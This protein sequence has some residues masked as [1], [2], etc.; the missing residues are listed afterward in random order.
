MTSI[1]VF[2]G[3]RSG[4]DP[5][6]R[7]A[8]IAFG[9]DIAARDL[10]LVYGGGNVGLMG[11]VAQSVLDHSGSVTGIIPD[12][13]AH[14]EV[15]HP[16]LTTTILVPDLFQRKAQMIEMS[17][18]FVALPGGIGTF[19]ELLE[20]VAW[21]QLKQLRCPIG[22]LDVADY[23]DPWFRA[24]EHSIAQGF[25]DPAEVN[26]IVRTAN[27][28]ELLNAMQAGFAAQQ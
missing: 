1:C 24:L 26:G 7:E 3:A 5:R 28:T 6:Y 23:F 13:L 12:F 22:V 2:C 14:Q 4:G 18:A 20:V 10:T 11:D 21:R 15:L 16:G 27:Q 8:A 9:R 17:D 25:I 19:D